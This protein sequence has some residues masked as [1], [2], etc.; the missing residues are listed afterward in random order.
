MSCQPVGP[1]LRGAIG[2]PFC[3][4]FSLTALPQPTQGEAAPNPTQPSLTPCS[5]LALLHPAEML[6]MMLQSNPQIQQV[7]QSLDA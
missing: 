5:P 7:G 3:I 6:R 4:S 2:R 1:N